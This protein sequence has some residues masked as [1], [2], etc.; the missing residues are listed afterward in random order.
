M[1]VRLVSELFLVISVFK[2]I[3][4]RFGK[5]GV[6]FVCVTVFLAFG[7]DSDSTSTDML[8]TDMG[9]ARGLG[10]GA[11]AADMGSPDMGAVV[12]DAMV[13]PDLG[14]LSPHCDR[15]A[16]YGLR[17]ELRDLTEG[18]SN[19]ANAVWTGN[20]WGVVWKVP[21]DDGSASTI[22]FQRFNG[23]G[24]ALGMVAEIGRTVNALPQVVA[25]ENG[26]VVAYMNARTTDD[27]F[28]GL[29]LRAVGPDGQ[30]AFT[31]INVDATFDV[32]DFS[33]GWAPFA[34]GMLLYSRGRGGVNGVFSQA[35][36]SSLNV[37]ATVRLTESKGMATAVSYGDGVWGAAWLAGDGAQPNELA[38]VL[39]DEGGGA[40]EAEQR[41]PGGGVGRIDIAYGQGTFG[42][43]WS[44]NADGVAP[45]P[46][47]TLIESGGDIIGT[48][49]VQG[50]DGFGL[51]QSV[52]WVGTSGFAIGW[53]A[54]Q[55]DGQKRAG[56]TRISTLGVPL[57]PSVLPLEEG[58]GHLGISV[59]GNQGR[60]GVWV[61][62]D[63]S[64]QA[65]GF[66]AETRTNFGVLGP[67][68]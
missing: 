58:S 63:P 16:G 35:I 59:A 8:D 62:N 42:V 15:A 64:P 9:G 27:P 53:T 52:S 31:S 11:M 39:L 33:L 5:Q 66:S 54:T 2:M 30:A 48:P 38:F 18:P 41:V 3:L 4:S 36:D 37:Q 49:P 65:V 26:Y 46:H 32:H 25:T 47:L 6:I 43:A 40:T 10:G 45:K 12:P 55:M 20:E 50:P 7:C 21:D 17:G 13:L 56:V 14:V 68:N 23:A 22:Y 44:K 34:G 60:L 29:R 24:T 28:S 61:T 67:C 19:S 51:A 1:N 57:Q